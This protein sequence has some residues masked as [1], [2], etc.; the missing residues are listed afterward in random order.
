MTML[1]DLTLRCSHAKMSR[2][3]ATWNVD[4]CQAGELS[5]NTKP[6]SFCLETSVYSRLSIAH[7]FK[8]SNT[9]KGLHFSALCCSSMYIDMVVNFFYL[10]LH[11]RDEC[12]SPALCNEYLPLFWYVCLT[13]EGK[14]NC[15]SHFLIVDVLV[16]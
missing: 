13:D 16:Y 3:N 5:I 4:Q 15:F 6:L 12:L 14:K 8:Y 1:K 2:L 10:A 7:A 9:T 11:G